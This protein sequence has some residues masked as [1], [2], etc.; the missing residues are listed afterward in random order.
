MVEFSKED[1]VFLAAAVLAQGY[2][3]PQLPELSN[4][5]LTSVLNNSTTQSLLIIGVIFLLL[6]SGWEYGRSLLS[7][8]EDSSGGVGMEVF[9]GPP[10]RTL[11]VAVIRFAGVDW[12]GQFGRSRGNEITYVEG[13][14]CPRCETELSMKTKSRRIRSK[15]KLWKCPSCSFSASRETD[16]RDSQRDMVEKIIEREAQDAIKNVL[17]RDESEIEEKV[18]DILKNAI[19]RESTVEDFIKNPSPETHSTEVREAIEGAIEEEV[20]EYEIRRY[21]TLRAVLKKRFGFT[22]P[23]YDPNYDVIDEQVDESEVK[24]RGPW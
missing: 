17:A 22:L 20:D 19:D 21:P 2:I 8:D 3:T 7:Q 14:Y 6:H 15:Q 18:D 16:T 13:P 24:R 4:G 23:D 1:L 11:Y 12:E 10:S 5:G 9:S